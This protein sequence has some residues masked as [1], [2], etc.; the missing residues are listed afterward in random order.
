MICS[1]CWLN[2]EFEPVTSE[3]DESAAVNLDD[4]QVVLKETNVTCDENNKSDSDD[5]FDAPPTKRKHR[6]YSTEKKVEIMKYARNTSIH[7]AADFYKIDR[8]RIREWKLNE[9]QIQASV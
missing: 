5:D 8:K 7:K 9:A 2:S 3:N 4:S 6:S 1:E